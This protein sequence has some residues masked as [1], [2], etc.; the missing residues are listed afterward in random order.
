VI[1]GGRSRPVDLCQPAATSISHERP[2]AITTE[3]N[4]FGIMSIAT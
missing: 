4:S 3:T 2:N 1:P